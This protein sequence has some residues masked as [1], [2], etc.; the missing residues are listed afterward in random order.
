[1]SLPKAANF[2]TDKMV[3]VHCSWTLVSRKWSG[4]PCGQTCSD[5]LPWVWLQ[6]CF[7][8]MTF[9]SVGRLPFL[10]RG[11]TP[12][13][14]GQKEAKVSCPGQEGTWQLTVSVGA[15]LWFFPV[16]SV[17]ALVDPGL[18]DSLKHLTTCAHGPLTLFRGEPGQKCT[19]FGCDS[20]AAGQ[21]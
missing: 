1:M 12:S 19:L 15:A 9:K 2:L 14:K 10:T 3:S 4:V 20:F 21:G 6:G 7:G 11:L 13:V 18:A 8:W 5:T 16:S 17:V